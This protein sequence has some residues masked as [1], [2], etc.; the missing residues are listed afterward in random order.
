MVWCIEPSARPPSYGR[1]GL[2][3]LYSGPLAPRPCH[4]LLEGGCIQAPP[5]SKRKTMSL[6]REAG[7]LGFLCSFLPLPQSYRG[8]SLSLSSI[9][10]ASAL[11]Q[12]GVPSL[13]SLVLLMEQRPKTLAS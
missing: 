12:A 2:S 6:W 8:C 3:M 5:A 10:A 9:P 7:S 4:G 1:R 11:G 13:S